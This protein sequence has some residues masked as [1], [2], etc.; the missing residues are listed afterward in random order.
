MTW[1]II[2]AMFIAI[3]IILLPVAVVWYINSTHIYSAFKGLMERRTTRKEEER[4][5]V[6]AEAVEQRK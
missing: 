4:E 6:V 2:V 3:P 5:A 1:Q